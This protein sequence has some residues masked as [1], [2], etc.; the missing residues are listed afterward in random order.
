MLY[1]GSQG[2]TSSAIT[3]RDETPAA[4]I[5]RRDRAMSKKDVWLQ[6]LRACYKYSLPNSN[7][8]AM[9]T[10]GTNLNWDVYD[11]TLVLDLRKFVNRMINALV[12]PDIDWVTFTSGANVPT[13][14]VEENNKRL[15]N[16]TD[17]FFFYLR[18]SNFDLA[19]HEALTDMAISTGV[20]Q[21]NEGDYDNPFVFS[22]IPNNT[23]AFESGPRGDINAFFRDWFRVCEDYA[24]E[25]W[26][27]D[28]EVPESLRKNNTDEIFMDL[29][30]ITYYDYTDKVYKYFV[31]EKSTALICYKKEEESWEWIGFRWSRMAGEDLGRGPVMDAMP[32][33][34]TI[35]KA[36]EYELA[37][38][39]LKAAPPLMAYTDAVINPY[40]L[41]VAPNSIIPVKR[42]GTETWPLM[43]LP[44]GGDI[45]FISIVI[46]DLRSQ[47]HEI[48]M[49]Q[50]MN[51]Q[52]D[53]K[54][55]TATE[56][57]IIQ[58][59]LR[60][61]AGAQFS[62]VQKELF[63]PLIKRLLWILKRKGLIE[64]I[65]IDGKEVALSYKTPLSV[66][67]NQNDVQK[68]IQWFEIMSGLFTPGVAINFADASKLPM[69]FGDKLG[70]E[71]DLIK[72]SDEIDQLVQ[73]AQEIAAQAQE[74]QQA[75]QPQPG[76]AP[77]GGAFQ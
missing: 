75:G 7:V 54:V 16:I 10:P 23:V 51:P 17:T 44:V 50:P 19:I 69:W 58:N 56:V 37:C 35:N 22:A 15:Q 3:R 57:S 38:G 30:E 52:Q 67:K 39:A 62:R 2:Q 40:T 63:D 59:E 45:S 8:Y 73:K 4:L 34:A 27:N 20:L 48:M 24:Y 43:P 61:N 25:L 13:D 32:T 72:N 64:P 9:T 41:N 21:A 28:F 11:N 47:I 36:M 49:A 77:S 74:Q 60:E 6:L 70:A 71:L 14:Q 18:Q 66:S 68:F 26:G 42:I 29:Y 5:K 12:P 65:V 1:S 55:R 31:I 53:D 33:A 46:N 76:Q